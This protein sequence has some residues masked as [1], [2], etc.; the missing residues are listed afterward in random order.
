MV[1]R[2]AP[3]GKV[4]AIIQARMGSTRLK[5]KVMKEI[6][7]KPILQHVLE[8][9]TASRLVDAS[10]LATTCNQEDDMLIELCD[11]IG[12]SSFRGSETDVLDRFYECAR[13]YGADTVVRITADCPFVDPDIIDKAITVFREG[14]SDYVSTAYPIQTFPDGLDVEVFSFDALRKAWQ[15]AKLLSEREHVTPYIWKNEKGEFKVESI[16]NATDLSDKRWTV[17]NEKDFIFVKTI[18]EALYS[19]NTIFKFDDIISYLNENPELEKIN[20]G[21]KRNEGYLKSLGEDE[22]ARFN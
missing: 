19:E 7:G 15:T 3:S 13:S 12:V 2:D 17:D 4:V 6:V 5:G 9:V 22:K 21:T 8:R 1:K 18:Y 16:Q 11:V 14:D 20:A 10:I